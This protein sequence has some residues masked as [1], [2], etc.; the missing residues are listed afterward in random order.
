MIFQQNAFFYRVHC[1]ALRFSRS[2]Y[3]S[4]SILYVFNDD[5]FLKVFPDFRIHRY[6]FSFHFLHDVFP[7]IFQQ[8]AVFLIGCMFCV[9]F[10]Q[11]FLFT[12]SILYIFPSCEFFQNAF[13]QRLHCLLKRFFL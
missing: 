5:F 4:F 2:F 1:F 11:E 3:I 8:G 6:M 7:V 12:C 13:F 10:F 9:M